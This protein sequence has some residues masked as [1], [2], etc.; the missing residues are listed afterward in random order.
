MVPGKAPT[1]EQQIEFV[2][3]Y[4][5]IK[6]SLGPG[7]A[8]LFCDAAHFVHQA[9]PAY[10]WGD[11]SFPPIL[12]TNTGRRRLNILGGYNPDT[13]ELIHL[14]GEENVDSH[15]VLDFLEIIDK[16][17]RRA[18]L[19][20]LIWDNASYFHAAN[21]EE[22]IENHPK[23][24]LTYLPC[25]APNLNLSERVWKLM[26]DKVVKNKYYEKYKTFRATVFQFLNNINNYIDELTSLMVEKFEIIHA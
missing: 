20:H 5:S 22:W 11:P 3:N 8:V 2:N 1:V 25:Y 4:R 21:V 15:R 13:H 7:A 17:Y 26:K 19:I 6:E 12:P 16:K 14:A 9:V 10:C 24:K 23:F 18:P